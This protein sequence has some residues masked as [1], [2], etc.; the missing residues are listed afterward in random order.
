[1]NPF[2]EG[3]GRDLREGI[4]GE[5]EGLEQVVVGREPKENRRRKTEPEEK[6]IFRNLTLSSQASP[7]MTLSLQ[8]F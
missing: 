5:D 1:V 2:L 3:G 6:E 7:E 8:A 4:D